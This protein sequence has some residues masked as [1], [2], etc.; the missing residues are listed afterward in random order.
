M[1]I[2]YLIGQYPAINHG[3]LLREVELLKS[4]GVEASTA[5]IRPPDRPNSELSE[6]ERKAAATTFYVLQQS[7]AR[8]LAAHL[9][10]FV[11]R[12]GSYCKGLCRALAM[13]NGRWLA[14]FAEA[15]VVG[16]WMES[17]GLRDVHL[18]FSANVGFLLCTIFPMRA[19]LG[20]YGY[21]ELIGPQASHL[22]RLVPALRLVRAISWH[23]RSIVMLHTPPETWPRIRAAP[24]GIEPE[25]FPVVPFREHPE[26]FTLTY[27]GRLAPEKGQRLLLEAAKKLRDQGRT[28]R[29]ILIG[30]G[31]S[32]AELE[33]WT[34]A[35]MSGAVTFEGW[36]DHHRLMECYRQTDAF[37]LTSLYEGIPVVLMEAMAMEIPCVAPRITGIPELIEDGVSGLLFRPSDID[38]LSAVLARLLDDLA[39]RARL[40]HEGRRHVLAHFDLASNTARFAE[41]L[42]EAFPPR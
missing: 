5:S 37:V 39:L 35:S 22:A 36:V 23:S 29:V 19:S 41:I 30:D 12:P 21:G 16:R 9:I 33:Q 40:A 24:L 27:V 1:K 7:F 3:Y 32:R 8:I 4:S 34:A 6:E 26:P 17:S 18:S 31:P 38:D 15:V 20:V 42:R 13:R 25:R 14:Y 10:T 28:I 11:R 2:A